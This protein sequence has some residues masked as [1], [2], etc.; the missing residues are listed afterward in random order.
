MNLRAEIVSKDL[1]LSLW[2]KIAQFFCASQMSDTLAH[3]I[4]L[5]L[6]LNAQRAHKNEL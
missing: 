2:L 4:A 6:S 3:K 1:S 5:S